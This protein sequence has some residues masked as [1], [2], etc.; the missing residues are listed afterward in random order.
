VVGAAGADCPQQQVAVLTDASEKVVV[1][2]PVD[3]EA[4]GVVEVEGDAGGVEPSEDVEDGHY[5]TS[6]TVP[7]ASSTTRRR[8]SS[9]A[10][11]VSPMGV[12]T[13][14]TGGS[15]SWPLRV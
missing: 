14:F 1:E 8:A 11:M 7:S 2:E 9:R 5:G 12:G 10:G 15:L 6:C 3:H 4:A 13:S